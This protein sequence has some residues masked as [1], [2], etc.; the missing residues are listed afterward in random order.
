MVSL[1]GAGVKAECGW[2]AREQGGTTRLIPAKLVRP[3]PKVPE[4]RCGRRPSIA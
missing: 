4:R 2:T 1:G 3:V